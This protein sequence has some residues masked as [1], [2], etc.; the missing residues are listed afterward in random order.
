M[1]VFLLAVIALFLGLLVHS[2]F[3]DFFPSIAKV[4]GIL[5]I[6]GAVLL[7]VLIV[8]DGEWV[9]AEQLEVMWILLGLSLY[10]AIAFF[11]GKSLENMF[12]EATWIYWA[13]A[14]LPFAALWLLAVIRDSLTG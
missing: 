10:V 11:V 14:L 1:V 5:V 8:V 6:L 3:P 9:T 12:G 4:L 13:A 7:V 2:Q